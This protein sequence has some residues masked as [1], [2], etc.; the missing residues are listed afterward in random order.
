MITIKLE[1]TSMF[2]SRMIYNWDSNALERFSKTD[3]RALKLI[4]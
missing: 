1:N 4:D 3:S 2:E